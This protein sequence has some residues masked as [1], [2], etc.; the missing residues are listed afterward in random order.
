MTRV[1]RRDFKYSPLSHT[2][3]GLCVRNVASISHVKGH[4]ER[5]KKRIDWNM[6]DYGIDLADKAADDSVIPDAR[7]SDWLV[8][9]MLSGAIPFRL[10]RSDRSHMVDGRLC[11]RQPGAAMATE[12]ARRCPV[13]KDIRM[14]ISFARRNTY[15]KERHEVHSSSRGCDENLLE[16][17]H[18][19]RFD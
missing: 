9:E 4:P 15:F 2:V 12:V 5:Y 14:L 8:A 11:S 17:L 19:R 3:L 13:F 10:V 6:N 7:I 1:Q 18:M 16:V